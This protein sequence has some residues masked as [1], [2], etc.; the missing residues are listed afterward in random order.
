MQRRRVYVKLRQIWRGTAPLPPRFLQPCP[1]S[2]SHRVLTSVADNKIYGVGPQ[3][4]L[5]GAVA[6]SVGRSQ[7]L[8]FRRHPGGEGAHAFGVAVLAEDVS[9]EGVAAAP[10]GFR[11]EN[12]SAVLPPP[13]RQVSQGAHTDGHKKTC[14]SFCLGADTSRNNTDF[15]T[16]QLISSPSHWF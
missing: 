12:Q 8:K 4:H 15:G 9:I 13:H 6:P 1:L 3:V 5:A 10:L 14:D 11:G 7:N 16:S 2:T